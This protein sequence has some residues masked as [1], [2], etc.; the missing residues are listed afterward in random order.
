MLQKTGKQ[1]EDAQH[2]EKGISVVS[3]EVKGGLLQ[4]AAFGAKT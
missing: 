1:G 2:W 4:Q 3:R